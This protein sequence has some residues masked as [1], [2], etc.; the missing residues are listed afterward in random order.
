MQHI[1]NIREPRFLLM[2]SPQRFDRRFGAVK[3]D[4]G[5]G[6][7]YLAGALRTEGYKVDIL[8]CSV[9]NDK[10]SLEDTFYRQ[11]PL[12][13]GMIRIGLTTEEIL[14]ELGEYDV[15]GIG[16]IFTAQTTMVVEVMKKIKEVYPEKLIITG[17]VNARSQKEL[18][19]DAGADIIFLSEGEKT[20][21]NI[22]KKLREGSRDFSDISGI[23]CK[24]EDQIVI[25]PN[26]F[27][28]QCLDNLPLPAWDMLPYRKY[29]KIARPHG[30]GFSTDNP[31]AYM[32]VMTSRGCL[33]ECD[34]C[35]I[36]EE[37]EGSEP[38]NIKKLRVKSL[39]R[40]ILEVSILRNLGVEHVFLEDDSL[41]GRKKR[42]K[43]IFQEIIRFKLK[44]SGVNG[45][46]IAHMCT[47]KDGKF[48][49][50]DE[51][52]EL[53]AQAGFRKFMLP[54]ESGS[55]RIIDKYA[56]GKL[57]LEKHDIPALIRKTKSLGME[58]G[59]N[60]TFG[61]PDET[62]EEVQSTFEI[63]KRHM[64]AGLSNANFMIITPFPG[65]T[66][67]NRV[68]RDNL[69]LPGV[70]LDELDWTQVSIKTLVDKKVLEE[71]I[72][73]GWENVNKPE[74]VNRIRSMAPTV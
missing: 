8:D 27:V 62:L 12:T 60:Y 18:F 37:V 45:I 9:G 1:K 61:Y 4:G 33:F 46:N 63:A 26:L 13:N 65:T 56:T 55:Q 39:Q 57:H 31:V 54:V 2:Y 21:L 40:T 34:F 3:P 32:P 19:F 71:M 29:W 16:S 69:F 66:F 50:D 20:I 15:I 35:H 25:T 17:G 67:F 38:G 5:L 48:V 7:T 14:G 49:V 36:G 11:K 52:L 42:A 59:G 64:D 24:R 22:G 73:T 68:V 6:L 41:L 51:L 72:T 58:V 44:L 47:G 70:K 10:Y 74:R 43:E 28:E 53:M 30:G 23:A